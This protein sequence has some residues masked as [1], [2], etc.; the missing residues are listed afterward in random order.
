MR[1]MGLWIKKPARTGMVQDHALKLFFC[2]IYI[3]AEGRCSDNGT[4]LVDWKTLPEDLDVLGTPANQEGPA[5]QRNHHHHQ[6]HH[7][8]PHQYTITHKTIIT[9]LHSPGR[10]TVHKTTTQCYRYIHIDNH[11]TVM[12][13][14]VLSQNCT[15]RSVISSTKRQ[16]NAIHIIITIIAISSMLSSP[17]LYHPITKLLGGWNPICMIQW[18]PAISRDET[19]MCFS[20]L[21]GVFGVLTRIPFSPGDPGCP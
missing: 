5:G 3:T 6:H 4:A 13:K 8:T 14:V 7:H 11:H 2:M 1:V 17:S 9:T 16:H 10:N 19:V 12:H 18:E 21:K 15:H 20:P